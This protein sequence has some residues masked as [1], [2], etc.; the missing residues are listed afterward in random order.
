MACA[1]VPGYELK[2]TVRARRTHA[3]SYYRLAVVV[4]VPELEVSIFKN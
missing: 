4:Y 1:C 3:Y 2:T